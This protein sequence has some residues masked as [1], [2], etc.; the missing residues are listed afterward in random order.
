MATGGHWL[1]AI[2]GAAI[3]AAV[4]VLVMLAVVEGLTAIE[5]VGVQVIGRTRGWRITPAIAVV[6]CDHASVGWAAGSA[7][8]AAGGA[9]V[10][11]GVLF[12]DLDAVFL[13]LVVCATGTVGG[14]LAFESLVYTGI[15]ASRFANRAKDPS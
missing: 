3:G 8:T 11:A 14:L 4:I 7:V 10:L 1:G 6:V 13:G 5:R 15:R 12:D 2:V 9:V